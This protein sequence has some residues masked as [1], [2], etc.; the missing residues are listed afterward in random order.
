MSFVETLLKED[1]CGKTILSDTDLQLVFTQL[2]EQYTNIIA[3]LDE[4]YKNLSEFI[5]ELLNYNKQINML[6]H[7]YL[8]I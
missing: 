3:I 1:K 7:L 4:K 8:P 6:I 2:T 5:A